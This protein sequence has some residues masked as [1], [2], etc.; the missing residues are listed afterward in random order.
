MCCKAVAQADVLDEVGRVGQAGLA[1][2]VVEHAQ[3]ARAGHEVDAVSAEVGERVAVPVVQH[4]RGRG[5]AHGT[6]DE[7]T[8]EQDPVAGRVR[9]HAGLEQ[10][11]SH[12]GPADLHAGLGKDPHRLVENAFEQ[13]VGQ[14]GQPWSHRVRAYRSADRLPGRG[15]PD[16]AAAPRRVLVFRSRCNFPAY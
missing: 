10:P 8:W 4:E 5:V 9:R 11:P 15:P 14:D 6:L 13:V 2:A 12:F 1:G 3:A 7:F 16:A